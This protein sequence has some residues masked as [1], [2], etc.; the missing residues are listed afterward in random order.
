MFI[1]IVNEFQKVTKFNIFDYFQRYSSFLKDEYPN[2]NLYYSGKRETIDYGQL[3]KLDSL[4]T[5]SRNLMRLFST[6]SNKLSNCGFWEL[7]EYCQ[8]LLD[9]LE[10][11]TKLPKYN[12]VSKTKYGYKP[13]IQVDSSVG[14]FRTPEDLAIEINSKNVSSVDIILNNELGEYK[15]EID[16]YYPNVKAYVDNNTTVVVPT[17]LEEQVGKQI[18]GKDI[19]AKVEFKENDFEIVKYE[20]NVEQKVNILLSII[21]GSVPE[22]PTFGRN[23]VGTN[24]NMYGYVELIKD[25]NDIFLQDPLFLFIEITE[26]NLVEGSVNVTC[27]IKT[28]YSYATKKILTL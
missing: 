1:D 8:N 6:F 13:Y 27:N 14:S 16:E 22:F 23:N 10:K 11:I 4:I 7:Q 26:I 9:T 20:D 17:I 24:A 15:W 12:R 28:K 2:I 5:E 19:K 21:R 18:Y 3:N 25:L